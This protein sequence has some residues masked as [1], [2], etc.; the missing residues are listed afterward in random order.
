MNTGD[1][2]INGERLAQRLAALGNGCVFCDVGV[3]AGVSSEIMLFY[4]EARNNHVIGIDVNECPP[5]LV[6]HPR[7]EF[8]QSD[9]VTAL[10]E[11][12][13]SDVPPFSA[14]LLDSLHIAEQVMCE[15]Y[16]I[17]PHLRVGGFV[18]YHDTA[19]PAGKH[20][21]YL[22]R[23]WDRV[24]V[25]IKRMFTGNGVRIEAFPESW[26]M[27]FVTKLA[28]CE[29]GGDWLAVFAARNELLALVP[30]GVPKR[31]ITS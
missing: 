6:G 26:G 18:A 21:H 8:I 16:F 23:D 15:T 1:L 4:A 7:Y 19:W 9:S 17:W 25:G 11:M 14:V 12:A 27:T 2:G 30:A 24:E 22:G 31:E 3:R 29:L 28:P 5:Q 13:D 10:E 20:D